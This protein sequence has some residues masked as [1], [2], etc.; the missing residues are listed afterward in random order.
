MDAIEYR[1]EF[2]ATVAMSDVEEMLLMAVIAAE[3][4]HGRARVLLDGD[5]ST[6]PAN[7]TCLI[8]ARSQVGQDIC[9][10][11][12]EFLNLEISEDAFDVSRIDVEAAAS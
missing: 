4:I 7:R 8:G 6:D 9:R 12:I 10:I 1:F 11:F 2:D 3:G 5:F